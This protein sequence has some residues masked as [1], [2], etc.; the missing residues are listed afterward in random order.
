MLDS[1]YAEHVDR[2]LAKIPDVTRQLIFPTW[3]KHVQKEGHYL[4]HCSGAD[5]VLMDQVYL[6]S[7]GNQVEACD[8]FSLEGH[9]VHVKKYTGSQT[10]SHLF[11]QGLV[12][13]D[14]L[15]LDPEYK[16]DFVAAVAA[17][18]E[19]HAGVAGEAPKRLVYAIAAEFSRPIPEGLP[20]FSKVNLREFYRRLTL[21]AVDV[22][23][24]K[25]V[26]TS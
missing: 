20:T 7:E 1:R 5:L 9:L 3:T 19:A 15:R 18:S 25:V 17:R 12:S 6:A 8:L 24:A 16:A 22:A 4:A 10:L 23:M 21:M 11:S 26:L 14:R 2:D 13:V